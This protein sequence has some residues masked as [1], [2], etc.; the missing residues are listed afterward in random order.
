MPDL[1]VLTAALHSSAVR[2]S[3]RVSAC[4]RV[5]L[6]LLVRGANCVRCMQPRAAS[7]V[8]CTAPLQVSKYVEREILNHKRLIHPH[9]VQLKEVSK[10][11]LHA[12]LTIGA[13]LLCTGSGQLRLRSCCRCS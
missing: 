7:S 12:R 5:C 2:A 11:A 4:L 13:Q 6:L 9:I 10:M 3:W 1:P 8:V